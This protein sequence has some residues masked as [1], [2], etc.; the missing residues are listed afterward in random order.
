MPAGIARYAGLSRRDGGGGQ[1]QGDQRGRGVA[2]EVKKAAVAF[3]QEVLPEDVHLRVTRDYGHT[4]DEK[5]NELVEALLVAIAIVVALLAYSLGWREGLIIALAVPITF[6]ITLL[7]NLLLGYTINRVTLFALILSLGL[8]V[9]DPIV[10]VENIHRHFAMRLLDPYQA[11]VRAVNE[12]RPPII[13]ATLAVI[14]S[15][16]PMFF[17]TGHD[18]PVHGPDGPE[19][20]D[21]HAHEPARGVHDHAVAELPCASAAPPSTRTTRHFVLEESWLYRVYQADHDAGLRPAV[22]ALGHSG[23]DRAAAGLCRLCWSCR[24]RCRSRCCPSTTRT[25]SRS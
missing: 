4:A 24:R 6:S 3:Q 21:R 7:I 8:V 22:A 15:F 9:D 16:V 13:L 25:S 5:V 17:I 20:A 10:D 1:T 2:E 12:V 19:R 18:G 14:I 23:R 11:I